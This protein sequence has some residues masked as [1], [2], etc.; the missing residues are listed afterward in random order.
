MEEPVLPLRLSLL[1]QKNSSLLAMR[2]MWNMMFTL[3]SK[4]EVTINA[5]CSPTLNFHSNKN[6]L[7]YAVSIDDEA[8]QIISINNEDAITYTQHLE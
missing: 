1:Q 2:P 5:Y 8:P 4:G 6:G 3:Y 7:Q